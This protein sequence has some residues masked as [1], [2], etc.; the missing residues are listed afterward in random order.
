MASRVQ[1]AFC[2]WPL[3][4]IAVIVAV[5]PLL[6]QVDTP[7]VSVLV[8]PN[9]P[10]PTTASSTLYRLKLPI[11]FL[12]LLCLRCLSVCP[13]CGGFWISKDS[14]ECSHAH[15]D[16]KI[17]LDSDSISSLLALSL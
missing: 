15:E 1:T 5:Q 14:L 16:A 11:Q 7:L 13:T 12:R 6:S 9:V 4:G 17:T 3:T 2:G 10:R 8:E